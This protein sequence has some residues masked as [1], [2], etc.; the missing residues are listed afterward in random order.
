MRGKALIFSALVLALDISATSAQSLFE[1]RAKCQKY[2]DSFMQNQIVGTYWYQ[3]YKSNFHPKLG[4]CYIL[5]EANTADTN[6]PEY[7]ADVYLY[8][9]VTKEHLAFTKYVK[10]QNGSE[11]KGGMIFDKYYIG[12]NY[13]YDAAEKYISDKMKT[14]R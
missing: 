12:E 13:N 8:D 1:Q 6:Q 4:N 5:V 9:A 14:E 10:K 7:K 3:T 11:L 2:A